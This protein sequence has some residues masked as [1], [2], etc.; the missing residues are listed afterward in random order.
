MWIY[1]KIIIFSLGFLYSLYQIFK[2]EKSIQNGSG[3]KDFIL[4]LIL[5]GALLIEN[6]LKIQ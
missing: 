4:L 6:I 1:I 3:R 5:F 2:N